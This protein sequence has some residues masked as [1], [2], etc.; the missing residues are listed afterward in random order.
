MACIILIAL[1]APAQEEPD[2]DQ[3]IKQVY[4]FLTQPPQ[5]VA[6]ASSLIQ[7]SAWEALAYLQSGDNPALADLQQAVPD[8]YNFTDSTLVLKLI[9]P[10]DNNE[11]GV[12]IQTP[13]RIAD[14]SR[15]LLLDA[16]DGSVRD[17]WLI[18][19]LDENYLALDMGEIK[20]FFT[21]TPAQE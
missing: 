18:I 15:I 6:E 13:Y 9:N 8:Y 5:P 7:P 10:E 2:A 4:E 17:E 3:V 21:H 1:R 20:V 16:K 14:N 19:G 12:E 11:Y